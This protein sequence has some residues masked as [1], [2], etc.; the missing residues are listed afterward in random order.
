MIHFTKIFWLPINCP[1]CEKKIL[2]NENKGSCDI[3]DIK[4]QEQSFKINFEERCNVCFISNEH[5]TKINCKIERGFCQG[6]KLY[7]DQIINLYRL[8]KDWKKL[9]KSWKFQ[10]NRFLYKSFLSQIEYNLNYIKNLKI[11]RIGFITSELKKQNIRSF[12]PCYDLCNY[13]ANQLN[14]NFGADLY[15]IKNEQQSQKEY[16]QR[17]FSIHNAIQINFPKDVKD[18]PPENYLLIEDVYTSG[19]TSNEASRILKKNGVKK[20]I[21]FTMLR[22]GI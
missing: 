7:F 14:I 19:S 16:G 1:C 11:D 13:L 5:K 9:V 6:R 12:Q 21:V 10:G 15:K 8:N 2:K 18:K 22:A 17:F 4:L 20:V 3:C